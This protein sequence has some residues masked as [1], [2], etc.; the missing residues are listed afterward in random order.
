M[1]ETISPDR[2]E[3]LGRCVRDAWVKW[4]L[5]Q[6]DP[7]PSW[8]VTWDGLDESD[9]V[10]AGQREA[11]MRIGEAM[12]RK[13]SAQGLSDALRRAADLARLISGGAL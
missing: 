11:D 2:R 6:G 1:S 12:A 9:P 5:E 10:D 4:A 3:E 13:R 8:L 7:S